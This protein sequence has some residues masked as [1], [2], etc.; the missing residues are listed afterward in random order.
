MIEHLDPTPLSNFAPVLLGQLKPKVCIITTPN[1]DFNAVFSLPFTPV[2]VSSTNSPTPSGKERDIVLGEIVDPSN[3]S[4]APPPPLPPPTVYEEAWKHLSPGDV[5]SSNDK[6]WRAGVPYGM[7]HP[8]HRFE[9]TREEFRNWASKAAEDFGYDVAFTGVGGLGNGMSVVG[10][11]GS[12]VS[13]AL[14]H[15]YGQLGAG[16]ESIGGRDGNVIEKAGEVWGDCSQIAIF[17]MREDEESENEDFINTIDW[18]RRLQADHDSRNSNSPLNPYV[19]P[20]SITQVVHH[21]FPYET[22]EIFPPSYLTIMEL[23]EN[24]IANYLPN[25]IREQWAKSPFE[26]LRSKSGGNK[27]GE[28]DDYFSFESD[29]ECDYSWDPEIDGDEVARRTRKKERRYE[30]QIRRKVENSILAGKRP[31][32]VEVVK[33]TGVNLRTLWEDS[34]GGKG[35]LRRVCRFKEEVFREVLLSGWREM[36]GEAAIGSKADGDSFCEF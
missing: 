7:R 22:D 28:R 15:E 12:A 18:K 30:K 5:C 19:F 2:S 21:N 24:E 34:I 4:R 11:S 25:R 8:D 35:G 3:L 27:H 31:D 32:I 36:L 9:W 20:N 33:V 29:S 13:D 26:L 14:T 17:T 6:Y 1:R 16:G 10:S 23:L